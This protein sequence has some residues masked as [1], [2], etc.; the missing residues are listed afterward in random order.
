MSIIRNLILESVDNHNKVEEIKNKLGGKRIYIPKNITEKHQLYILGEEICKELENTCVGKTLYI[1]K[2]R[3]INNSAEQIDNVKNNT[4]ISKFIGK[5]Y[6]FN[7]L[8]K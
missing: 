4:I 3:L 6:K 1:P 7:Q 5:L 8:L 2:N